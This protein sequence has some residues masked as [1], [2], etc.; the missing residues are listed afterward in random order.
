M[1]EYAYSRKEPRISSDTSTSRMRASAGG[2]RV[3]ACVD[4][5]GLVP[6]MPTVLPSLLVKPLL[7]H[8]KLVLRPGGR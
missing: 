5:R 4:A 1:T 7:V 2:V 3:D 8:R 6:T